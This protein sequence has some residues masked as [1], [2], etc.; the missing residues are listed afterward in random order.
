MICNYEVSTNS[1]NVLNDTSAFGMT[2]VF[3]YILTELEVVFLFAILC[4][5]L[6]YILLIDRS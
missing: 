1:N 2:I 3:T 5:I 6:L 4:F